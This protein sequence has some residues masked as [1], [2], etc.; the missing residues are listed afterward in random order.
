[1]RQQIHKILLLLTLSLCTHICSAA[2]P[3]ENIKHAYSFPQ[4]W[5]LSVDGYRIN[6]SYDIE[7]LTLAISNTNLDPTNINAENSTQFI[8]LKLDRWILP[9]LNIFAIIGDIDGTTEV[10]LSQ[11]QL[12]GIPLS[13]GQTEINYDGEL[14]GGGF[15]LTIGAKKWFA[16]FTT[17][18]SETN[19]SGSFQSSINTMTLQPKIGLS[20]KNINFWIGATYL[21]A[22][23]SHQGFINIPGS[24]LPEIPFEVELSNEDEINYGAG[25]KVSLKDTFDIIAEFGTGGRGHQSLSLVWRF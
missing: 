23:E 22:D 24:G 10:G 11:I 17:T 5:G 3:N 21:L 19:L 8:G 16:S 12:P 6:Q 9:F 2:R 1:M 14:F 4:P 20:R 7:Q 13:L 25:M 15:T 18:F